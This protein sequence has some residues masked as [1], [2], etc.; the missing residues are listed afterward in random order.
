MHRRKK[1]TINAKHNLPDA[2]REDKGH[3]REQQR[4]ICTEG[5]KEPLSRSTD[6]LMHPKKK[7][8][9]IMKHSFTAAPKREESHYREAQPS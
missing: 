6:F 8:V 9:T 2:P 7:G 4:S 5:N 1:G 3:F